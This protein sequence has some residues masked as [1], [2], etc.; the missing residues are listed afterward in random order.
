MEPR[1]GIVHFVAGAGGH[2]HYELD[3]GYPGLAWSNETTYG[4]LRLQL[5]P[6]RARYAFIS[7][8]GRTL[9]SGSIPC[10]S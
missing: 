3:E 7:E 9:D 5:S 8:R 1:D 10:R 2:S 4:A 6:G